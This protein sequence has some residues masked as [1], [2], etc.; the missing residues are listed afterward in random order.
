VSSPLSSRRRRRLAIGAVAGMALVAA[1]I[2]QA[3]AGVPARAGSIPAGTQFYVDPN[4]QAA[5]W[6]AANPG[7]S[8]ASAINGRIA[9]VP[10]GIWFSSYSPSTVTSSVSA[11][12]SAAKAAG[13]T[14][15]LVVYEIPNRDCGGASAGG[16]PD[17]TSYGNWVRG[18]AAG[19]DN[20]PVVVILEPDSLALQ[21]CL[22]TSDVAARDGAIAQAVT[23]IKG[24]DASAKVYLD[25]GH[26]AWNSAADQASRLNAAGVRSSDGIFSNVS[27]FNLTANEVSFDK[28]VLSALGN[29]ANLHA[30]VDTSRNGNGS[31]GQWCDPSGRAL[32]VTPTAG[33]GDAA[34]D[35][36]LWVKPPGEAD[37]C[38]DAA[39]VFDPALAY[40]LI[41]NGPPVSPSPTP[42]RSASPS[43]SPSRTVSPSPT[44]SPS[45]TVSTSPTGGPNGAC[46][47]TYS[48]QS[49]W[50][51]GFV[52]QLTLANTGTAAINGWTLTFRFPGDQVIT[53][54][55]STTA[56][57]SGPAVT[58]T[59]LSYNG[60]VAAGQSVSIGFQGTWTSSDASPTSFSV[61]GTACS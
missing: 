53:S 27:N 26:S 57:Q 34:I 11:V 19:L 14:P 44:M 60:A 36:Y 59:N 22:S 13:Q 48:R 42:T 45:P 3:V 39:G 43:P 17:L 50:Q 35:A 4:S 41:T 56:S 9:Q 15:V 25:A 21:T 6:V 47:V 52:A 8:R 23:T 61:N 31:N 33:T 49:E 2:G 5:R 30:V 32:G 24:A 12:T 51:G 55:W 7:D 28:A 46:H 54:A 20:A 1:A 37:G 58:L 29:P 38:A 10:A 18:F 16:A 40:A